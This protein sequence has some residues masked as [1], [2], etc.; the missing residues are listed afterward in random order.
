MRDA[1]GQVYDRMTQGAGRVNGDGVVALAQAA[2]TSV[3]TA[4]IGS[5]SR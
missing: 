4:P 2:D 5:R 3:R 1:S